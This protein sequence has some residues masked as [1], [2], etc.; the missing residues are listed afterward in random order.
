MVV[1]RVVATRWVICEV[2]ICMLRIV[3]PNQSL[4]T[5]MLSAY[6]GLCADDMTQRAAHHGF[7]RELT[8]R[9]LASARREDWGNR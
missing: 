9:E 5:V 4:T 1:E 6:G 7:A 8:Q 3:E 2:A